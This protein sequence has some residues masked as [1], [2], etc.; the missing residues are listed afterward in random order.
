VYFGRKRL[1]RE[2][3]VS[4]AKIL[5][6]RDKLACIFIPSN[7]KQSARHFTGMICMQL[8]N[9]FFFLQEKSEAQSCFF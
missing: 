6:F 1:W 4:T 8:L 7:L 3:G 9:I 2:T 5:A